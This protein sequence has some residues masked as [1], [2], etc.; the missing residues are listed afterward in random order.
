MRL[1]AWMVAEPGEDLGPGWGCV[2]WVV[3]GVVS[4]VLWAGVWWWVWR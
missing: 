4:G 3:A 2:G 1:K